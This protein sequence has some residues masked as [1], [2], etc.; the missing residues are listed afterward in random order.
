MTISFFVAGK[1]KAKGTLI[2]GQRKDGRRFN[3][4]DNRTGQVEW[5]SHVKYAAQQAMQG[6]EPMRGPVALALTF[7]FERPRK[8]FTSKGVLRA[9]YAE[10]LYATKPDWDKVGRSIG[11]ALQGAVYVD[12]QQVTTCI[13]RMRYG[14]EGVLIVALPD[15]ADVRTPL[16]V[17]GSNVTTERW[18]GAPQQ[19]P[20][21]LEGNQSAYP[22]ED[23]F[24]ERKD[25]FA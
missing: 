3:R 1:P 17:N 15:S 2:T 4:T 22:D 11:D 7:F 12:D 8:H 23:D 13:T 14:H 19:A 21:R 25:D 18:E 10:G 5:A 6:R 24:L 16:L 9:E 20:L